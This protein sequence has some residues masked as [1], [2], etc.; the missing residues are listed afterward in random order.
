MPNAPITLL[1]MDKFEN[2][3]VGNPAGTFESKGAGTYFA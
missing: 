1:R 3:I 2:D